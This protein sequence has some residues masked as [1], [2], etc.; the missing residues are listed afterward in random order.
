M[1]HRIRIN[2]IM[3]YRKIKPRPIPIKA[4]YEGELRKKIAAELK[5]GRIYKAPSDDVSSCALF[6]I[7]KTSDPSKTKFLHDPPQ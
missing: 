4:V 7:A 1:N 3:A 5:S 2:D 6:T